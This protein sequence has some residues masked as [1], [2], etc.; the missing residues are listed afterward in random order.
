M[1]SPAR[2]ALGEKGFHRRA[3]AKPTWGGAEGLPQKLTVILEP[4]TSFTSATN[5]DDASSPK[6]A[7]HCACS[8]EGPGPSRDCAPPM[9]LKRRRSKFKKPRE[10]LPLGDALQV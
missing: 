7:A 2:R 5:W 3:L 1:R 10:L 8:C 4:L 9:I 6:P